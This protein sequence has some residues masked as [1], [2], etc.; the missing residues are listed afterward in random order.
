M[1]PVAENTL[2][3]S[4]SQKRPVLLVNKSISCIVLYFRRGYCATVRP[5]RRREHSST[6]KGVSE[7]TKASQ[8]PMHSSRVYLRRSDICHRLDP[9][10]GR[11]WPEPWMECW[12]M[13]E[14]HLCR[15]P[16]DDG[17]ERHCVDTKG[18]S[19]ALSNAHVLACGSPALHCEHFNTTQS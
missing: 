18:P 6:T 9:S 15:R 7:A 13:V 14:Q 1:P 8:L 5:Y 17:S 10:H 12:I 4:N 19:L 11:I 16:D 2:L 3:A